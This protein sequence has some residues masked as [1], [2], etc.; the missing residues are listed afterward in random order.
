MYYNKVW[1]VM[2]ISI[3]SSFLITFLLQMSSGKYQ[4]KMYPITDEHIRMTW[5]LYQ[6]F[7]ILMIR[8]IPLLNNHTSLSSAVFFFYGDDY[9]ITQSIF[10]C[11]LFCDIVFHKTEI[12]VGFKICPLSSE[13][14]FYV[15][16]IILD[17][18]YAHIF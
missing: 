4:S 10:L 7:S 1:F 17:D 18:N 8:M 5:I 3:A 2:G 14:F 15:F 11:S 12:F 6:I 13:R 16:S 9:R